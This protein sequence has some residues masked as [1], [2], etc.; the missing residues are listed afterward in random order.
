MAAAIDLAAKG[1]KVVVFEKNDQFGGRGR[2]FSADGFTFDMGPS[3]YWMP[4]IFETFFNKHGQSLKE[5]LNLRRL[6]PSYRMFFEDQVLD[7]PSDLQ[8]VFQVFEKQEPGSS[9]FLRKFLDEAKYKYNI[10]MKEYVTRP[11]LSIFEY[12]DWKILRSVFKLQM[13]Q[14]IA[15][16]V[17]KGVSNKALRAWLN[18]PVLFLGAKPKDTPALYSLMNYADLVLG[19]WYPEGGMT[20]LFEAFYQLSLDKGVKYS[21]S[22]TVRRIDVHNNK[23]IGIISDRGVHP[24]DFIISAAD[25]QHT[26]TQLL[27]QNQRQ[28]SDSYWNSRKMAPGA[29]IF[30]LG[31]KGKIQGLLHHNLFFDADFDQHAAEIYDDKTWPENPLFYVC[32]NSY[33]D[34]GV[35]PADHENLFLLMPISSGLIEN[36]MHR[37]KYLDLML[38]RMEKRTSVRLKDKIVFKRSY[39]NSDFVRDYNSFKGNA[40]GLANTLSQTAIL[41]PRLQHRRIKNLFF[42]GQL[43]HPGPGL[44]PSMISG[45]I[46][47]SLIDQMSK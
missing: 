27:P 29:L 14:S 46:V 23:A 41:K 16:V 40:Y 45:E 39:G 1:H 42:A 47:S 43:S 13:T 20:R 2:S 10:G 7:S 4:D 28:Y 35:A 6:S 12:F 34:S 17:N 44:P 24:F 22:D 30:Y 38:D 37:E 19:T 11:S 18:F 21:F 33:S 32:M 8:E 25:Y 36:E 9:A 31:I 26:D 15:S 3:W 5:Q